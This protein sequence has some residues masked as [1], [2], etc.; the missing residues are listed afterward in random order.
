MNECSLHDVLFNIYTYSPAAAMQANQR[1]RNQENQLDPLLHENKMA[2]HHQQH[3]S[4]EQVVE[5]I[6][7]SNQAIRTGY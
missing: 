5:A 4:A 6:V 7:M 3:L 2:K 1:H